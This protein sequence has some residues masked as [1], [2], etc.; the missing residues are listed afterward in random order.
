[1]VPSINQ[2]HKNEG[3]L[4]EREP[5]ERKRGAR[6]STELWQNGADTMLKETI[7]GAAAGALCGVVFVVMM[8]LF[9]RPIGDG[10]VVGAA[11]SA[12]IA[13]RFPRSISPNAGRNHPRGR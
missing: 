11:I 12:G 1:M 8:H 10:E 13:A 9:S 4:R 3:L 7:V 6:R 2:D 5:C